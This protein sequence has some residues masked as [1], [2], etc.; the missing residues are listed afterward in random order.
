MAEKQE[1]KQAL[2]EHLLALRNVLLISVGA[3]VVAFVVI[4]CCAIDPLMAFIER[5]LVQ[6]G[7]SIIFTELSE[8]VMA[9]MKMIE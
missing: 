6:R 1:K 9:K 7:I 5:P 3:V 2:V 4:F 8:G